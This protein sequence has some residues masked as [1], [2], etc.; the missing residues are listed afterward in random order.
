MENLGSPRG[1]ARLR[2]HQGGRWRGRPSRPSDDDGSLKAD[3]R[4]QAG[5][6]RLPGQVASLQIDRR[7]PSCNCGKTFSS[8]F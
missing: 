8:E 5:H 6:R 2:D 4:R 1:W 3:D 7:H